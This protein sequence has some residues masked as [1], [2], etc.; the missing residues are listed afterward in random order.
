MTNPTYFVAATEVFMLVTDPSLWVKTKATTLDGA[1]RLATKQARSTTFSAY[2]ATK[3]AELKTV[4]THSNTF[5]ITRRRPKW[6]LH[7]S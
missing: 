7:L 1:K 6:R 2:V 4:A 3:N 5:V